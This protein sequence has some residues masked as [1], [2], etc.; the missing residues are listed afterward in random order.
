MA[1]YAKLAVQT[2]LEYRFNAIADWCLN[3]LIS[4]VV[5]LAMW[6]TMF[7]AMGVSVLGGFSQEYYLSYVTWATF[8]SR[9]A[10]NWMYEFRMLQ[11]V[12]SGGINAILVRPIS[13]YEFYLGQFMGY[14]IFTAIFSL[15]LPTLIAL[16]LGGTTDFAR[17]PVSL[18]LVFLYLVF[19]YTLS[20]F[21]TTFAFRLTKVGSFTVTKNFFIWLA[22]GELFPLD[23]LPEGLKKASFYFPFS[24]GCYIPVGFLTHRLGWQDVLSGVV[25]TIL[26]TL[27]FG[28]VAAVSWHR[29][30]R[31]YSG[32]GA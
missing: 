22:S 23:L 19:T 21:I 31:A 25:A 4:T 7:R 30:L 16:A 26:W 27:V 8:F 6:W 24:S 10:A 32:T 5:E 12:E 20:F 29:G 13:F 3:P 9:I 18:L 28:F 11:E 2:Q 1:A 17:L 15:W 14:K